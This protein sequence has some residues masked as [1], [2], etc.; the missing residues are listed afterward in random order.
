M[1]LSTMRLGVKCYDTTGAA[2][3][4]LGSAVSTGDFTT[5][6]SAQIGM[7]LTASELYANPDLELA[8]QYGIMLAVKIGDQAAQTATLPSIA[9]SNFTGRNVDF[10]SAAERGFASGIARKTEPSG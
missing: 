8:P 4:F 2:E 5:S 9:A 1:S 7:I 3:I 10:G 6:G